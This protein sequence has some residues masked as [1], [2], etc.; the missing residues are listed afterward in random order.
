MQGFGILLVQ[1]L[2][3]YICGLMLYIC[4]CMLYICGCIKVASVRFIST[5]ILFANQTLP[6]EVNLERV[7]EDRMKFG[8]Q[9]RMV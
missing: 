8:Q 1:Y 3:L 6:D 9:L 4:G 5:V 2:L 7:A